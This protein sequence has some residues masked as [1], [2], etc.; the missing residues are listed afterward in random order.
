MGSDQ[1]LLYDEPFNTL[2]ETVGGSHACLPAPAALSS[3]PCQPSL[4]TQA[5]GPQRG[6]GLPVPNTSP[7]RICASPQ[8]RAASTG[9]AATGS[10]RRECVPPHCS[11]PNPRDR[12][13]TL[14]FFFFL[15][16][17]SN[18]KEQT[19]LLGSS[20]YV[21]TKLILGKRMQ[22][23]EGPGWAGEGNWVP[24]IKRR[25]QL[26]VWSP[27]KLIAEDSEIAAI[28]TDIRDTNTWF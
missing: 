14:N 19:Y 26:L 18:L 28:S 7:L 22:K 10:A 27:R 8:K 1:K 25:V 17:K 12:Y 16:H 13:G 21:E 23:W 2:H 9:F 15:C 5:Q 3:N 4:V 11:A 6:P 24:L 20:S